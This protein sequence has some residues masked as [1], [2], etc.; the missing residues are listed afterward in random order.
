M[1]AERLPPGGRWAP[2]RLQTGLSDD[3]SRRSVPVR[4]GKQT[5]C[6][7]RQQDV[8]EDRDPVAGAQER[9][10]SWQ[11]VIPE[12]LVPVTHASGTFCRRLALGSRPTATRSAED[13]PPHHTLTVRP[14]ETENR[15]GA[16]GPS[17]RR[18]R[19]GRCWLLALHPILC[20]RRRARDILRP[21]GTGFP[22]R[23]FTK[24]PLE[25]PGLCLDVSTQPLHPLPP[26][27]RSLHSVPAPALG[28]TADPRCPSP[29][30]L[31][32]GNSLWPSHS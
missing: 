25:G 23:P 16:A 18:G 8:C 1:A 11:P 4:A 26:C 12:T 6:R 27:C 32:Q 10:R 17:V 20:S 5:S 3:P 21:P 13:A 28:H 22:G 19:A 31:V 7:Q 30:A 9:R 2:R 14:R 15:P 29:T 24:A